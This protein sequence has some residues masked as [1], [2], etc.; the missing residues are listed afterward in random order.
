MLLAIE[1]LD[2]TQGKAF[3]IGGGPSQSVSLLELLDLMELLHEP[4][5]E[6]RFSDWRQGDQ[7]YYVSD[8]S[9]FS[10]ATGWKP[11]IGMGEGVRR[12]Y[13]WLQQSPSQTMTSEPQARR[14]PA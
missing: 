7:R 9:R 11:R 5:P 10:Q 4:M 14:R 6:L 1:R 2:Q 13:Q 3:N 8:T 12:L